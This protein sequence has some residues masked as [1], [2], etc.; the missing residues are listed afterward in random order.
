MKLKYLVIIFL[1]L[2]FPLQLFGLTLEEEKKYGWEVYLEIARS[3]QINN[4]PYISIH[5]RNIKDRLEGAASIPFPIVLTIIESN[6]VDAFATIG[7]YVYLTT[8]LIGLCDKEEELAGVLAHE[9]AHIA[10]RHVAKRLGKEKFISVGT[11][12]SLLLA[13][14]VPDPKAQA[15]MIAMGTASSMAMSLKYSREDEEEADSFGASMADKAGYGGIGTV[16]FL[17]KL[18]AGGGDKA[19]PQYLLTHPYHEER[20]IR[21]ESAWAGKKARI[22]DDFFPFLLIRVKV[23]HSP[24]KEDMGDMWINRYLKDSNN[25]STG[26]AMSLMYSMK[27]D[28]NE[29]VNIA[30][31]INSPYRDLFLGEILVNSRRFGEA[32]G[33]LKDETFPVSRF[34]LAKAYE[35]NGDRTMALNVL[36]GLLPYGNAYPEI[37]YRYGMLLGRGGDEAKGYAYLGRFYL[38]SGKQ[39]LAR[40]NFEKAIAKYGI[41]SKEG[42]EILKLLDSTK[43][44]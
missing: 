43:R 38:M 10:R 16:E 11:L 7:G 6:S 26:Y 23:L 39:D 18:R 20:I 30:K 19:L 27:G 36:N 5:L 9:F 14:L 24:Q 21:I 2:F 41:N 31:K 40:Q 15:A 33:V 8:G 3:T 1:I 42:Q 4:D 44:K 17:R 29:S 35:G 12:A 28:A 32:I 34:F 22:D 13:M 37:F 25:P